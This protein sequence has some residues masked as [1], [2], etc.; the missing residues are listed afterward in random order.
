MHCCFIVS[1]NHNHSYKK[2]QFL[3]TIYSLTVVY[4]VLFSIWFVVGWGFFLNGSSFYFKPFQS[5]CYLD[6]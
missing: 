5:L 1:I 2:S 4:L 3:L 6:R